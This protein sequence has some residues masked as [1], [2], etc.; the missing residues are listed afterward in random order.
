MQ[1]HPLESLPKTCIIDGWYFRCNNLTIKY[2][3][4]FRQKYTLKEEYYINNP[5][6]LQAASL[7]RD[8]YQKV[9][10]HIRRGDYKEFQG[11]KYYYENDVFLKYMTQISDEISKIGKKTKFYLFSNE[12][13]ASVFTESFD[14]VISH[15]PWYIDQYL[16]TQ[17]DY[18]I[19]PPSTFTGWASYI[20]EVPL[21][22]METANDELT[23]DKFKIVN[24]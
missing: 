19:G 5:L 3:S 15:N 10:V 21:F 7:N 11:G 12:P 16:M 2:R 14:A 18:L 13:I 9:G 22:F 17:M 24:G 23:L 20:N 8:E 6:C 4:L 1:K